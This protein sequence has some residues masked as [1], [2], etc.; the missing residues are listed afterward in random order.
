M[1]DTDR[2][3]IEQLEDEDKGKD[4]DKSKDKQTTKPK[5]QARSEQG[6]GWVSQGATPKPKTKDAA[7]VEVVNGVETDVDEQTESEKPKA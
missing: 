3:Q 4:K 7:P 5:S 1:K 6:M 2:K